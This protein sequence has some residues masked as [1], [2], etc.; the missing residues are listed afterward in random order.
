MQ[1]KREWDA[2]PRDFR[3]QTARFHGAN[4]LAGCSNIFKLTILKDAHQRPDYHRESAAE[5]GCHA[6]VIYYHPRIVCHLA[7]WLRPEHLIRTWHSLDSSLVPQWG[8]IKRLNRTLLSGAVSGAYPLRRR[9]FQH[10]RSL[11]GCQMLP[12]PGYHM[13][14]SCTPAFLRSLPAY[15]VSICTSSVYGYALRKIVESTACGCVVITDLPTDEVM[16]ADLAV[17]ESSID[18]NLVRVSPDISITDMAEV[19]ATCYRNWNEERQR[20]FADSAKRWHDYR[21]VTRKLS[22]DIE[23][24]RRDYR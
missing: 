24:M 7:P 3:D 8:S 10:H 11:P 23:R 16:Q 19:V 15:K 22:D 17:P 20:H 14:K 13:R 9:L 5:I 6:W 12:H 18:G 2:P 4:E 1:D 21:E